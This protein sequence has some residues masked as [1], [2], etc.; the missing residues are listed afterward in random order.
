[1]EGTE[2]PPGAATSCAMLRSIWDAMREAVVV[3]D[4]DSRIV[5]CNPAVEPMFGFRCDEMNGRPLAIIQPERLRAAHEAGMRR[6]FA[7]DP[8]ATRRGGFETHGRHRDGQEFPIEVALAGIDYDD[9]CCVMGLVRDI[10]ERRRGEQE[11]IER[12]S[13]EFMGRLSHDLRTPLHAI[14]GFSTLLFDAHTGALTEAQKRQVGFIKS[15]GERLLSLI[16]DLLG[17]SRASDSSRSDAIRP[18]GDDDLASGN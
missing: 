9:R 16:D 11:R 4:H 7:G 10:S 1:M 5:C 8:R 15:S 6:Y 14:L 2:Q 13:A 12:V 18:R 17:L 3:V